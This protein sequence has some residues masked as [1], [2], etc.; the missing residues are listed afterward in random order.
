MKFHEIPPSGSRAADKRNNGET[1]MTQPIGVIRDVRERDLKQVYRFR[2]SSVHIH[3]KDQWVNVG[4]GS[5]RY[6]LGEFYFE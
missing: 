3:C 4:Y 2:Y 1:D 6:S 5:N